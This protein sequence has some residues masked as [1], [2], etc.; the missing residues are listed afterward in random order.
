MTTIKQ[1]NAI[2][3]C[4]YEMRRWLG[5]DLNDPGTYTTIT[6]DPY[7]KQLDP[8]QRTELDARLFNLFTIIKKLK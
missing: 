1:K 5:C 8:D 7:V 6:K 3:A 2:E 4:R